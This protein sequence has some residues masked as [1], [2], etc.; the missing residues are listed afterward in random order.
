MIDKY[1]YTIVDEY[2]KIWDTS[3]SIKE[4][5]N[6]F[7]VFVE[8]EVEDAREERNRLKMKR[9]VFESALCIVRYKKEKVIKKWDR[10][11]E[12]N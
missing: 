5:Q 2:G 10:R 3:E 12:I 1:I 8:E 11:K 4:I 6:T 7:R 9:L